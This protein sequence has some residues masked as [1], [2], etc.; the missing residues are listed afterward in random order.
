MEKKGLKFEVQI[1]TTPITAFVDET[2]IVQ[3]FKNLVDNAIKY[4]PS[5]TVKASLGID[6]NGLKALFE[7]KDT[8]I[9][10]T[11]SDKK[12]L[13][14]EGGKGEESLKYN[15]DSA[16]YGL[17]IVKKIVETHKG[18]IW[19]ESEGRG[20]GSKFCVELPIVQTKV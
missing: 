6:P 17:Y 8:G 7:I 11:D 19:A 9:G 3:V 13:F 1:T 5:G 2:Q 20:K 14:T 16:G 15:T 4:S 12:R 18:K 10:L